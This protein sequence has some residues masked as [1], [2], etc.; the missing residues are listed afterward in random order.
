MTTDIL[1]LVF[2]NIDACIIATIIC[3]VYALRPRSGGWNH[4][5]N[6]FPSAQIAVMKFNL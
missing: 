1:D 5:Y 2:Q 6:I 4:E 3:T